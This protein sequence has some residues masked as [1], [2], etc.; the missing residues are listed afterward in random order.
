MI[1]WVASKPFVHLP[2]IRF[3]TISNAELNLFFFSFSHSCTIC[4]DIH[5]Q[6]RDTAHNRAQNYIIVCGDGWAPPSV[7][8]DDVGGVNGELLVVVMVVRIDWRWGIENAAPW[9]NALPTDDSLTPLWRMSRKR[10]Q[11]CKIAVLNYNLR[12]LRWLCWTAAVVV[13]FWFCCPP[14]SKG[15]LFHG[16]ELG[17]KW[18]KSNLIRNKRDNAVICGKCYLP[19]IMVGK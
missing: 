5:T 3:E 4:C 9:L 15:E 13:V 1:S 19:A 11:R 14:A 18:T 7:A 16:S 2:R 6:K 10:L 12:W 17:R 8:H